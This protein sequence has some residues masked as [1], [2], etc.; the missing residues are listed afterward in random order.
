MR[1]NNCRKKAGVLLKTGFFH[2]FGSSVINKIISFLNS[3]VLVRILSKTEYGIFTY[4][5][6]IYS[7]IILVNGLG[8]DNGV[9]QICSEHSGD[10]HY[11]KQIFRY[12]VRF[13]VLVDLILLSTIVGIGL[14]APLRIEKA[15]FFL[16]MTCFLPVIQIIYNLTAVF[17]RAEKRNQDYARIS[18]INTIATFIFAVIGAKLWREA[19]LII[20]YYCAGG[21]S[22][23][24]GIVKYDIHL[25]NSKSD[26]TR[27]DK[28]GLINISIVSMV[29]CG[30]SQLLYLLDIFVLGIAAADETILAS[31]K[32]ATVIPT[33]LLFIP[34]SLMLYVYPYF[35]GHRQDTKWCLKHYKQLLAGLA[36]INMFISVCLILFAPLIVTLFFGKEYLDS[37]PIF[38]LLSLNFFFAGTFRLPSG[39]LLVTQRELTFN[40]LV[41]VV[42]GGVN[43]CADFFFIS[44][45]GSQGAAIATIIVVMISSLM[46]TVRLFQVF[47]KE[48][49]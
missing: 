29:N 6:N 5:W 7:L 15:R 23:F 13:G 30:L 31:Y 16:C 49:D 44:K 22:I 11:N 32:V 45:W 47:N 26:R 17:L 18:M 35:A 10:K 42:S 19:G 33:A 1:L 37:V 8:I 25:W 27:I 3:I 4:A 48:T 39:N 21:V 34:S 24:F 9:L 43:V 28:K 36:A 20:A 12:G 14:L 40:T 46:S 38:R 2:I 41:A